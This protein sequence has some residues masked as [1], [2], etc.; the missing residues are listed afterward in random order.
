VRD[1]FVSEV[2][3][4]VTFLAGPKATTLRPT[5]NNTEIKLFEWWKIRTAEF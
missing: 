2:G 5:D 1:N 3:K 4:D